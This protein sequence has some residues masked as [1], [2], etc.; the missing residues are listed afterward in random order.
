MREALFYQKGAENVR[1]GL[2][3]HACAI[4]DGEAGFCRVRANRG[5]TLYALGYGEISSLAVD[6]IEKKPLRHFYPGR[7][8]L[9]AGSYGCNMRCGY[10][11]NS[12]ISQEKPVTESI[13]PDQM[14]A[15]AQSIPENLG[16]A[17]TY[18]EPLMSAEY[19]LDTAP[20]IQD[21]GLK[22]VLVTNGLACREPLAAVLPF[23]D[24]MN[25][26]IKGFTPEFYQ[27]LGGR[28]ET[29]KETVEQ[30]AGMCHVEATMLVIP[31]END[32]DAEM[33]ALSE[34]LAGVS[35]DIPLHL[36]RFFPGYK[37]KE[38]AATPIETL[39]RLAGLAHRHLEHVYLGNVS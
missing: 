24:A 4:K 15:L 23:V 5:G 1:C 20:L 11:Q 9:S 30:C 36:S 28:L 13:S 3:P 34:W 19:L 33:I 31:G 18:N 38:K 10:C 21:M 32:S 37:M 16:I 39:R 7:V 2:C 29:V 35:R 6:P 22:A 14:A 25:I 17:F 12:S 27:K 8:I 26:D